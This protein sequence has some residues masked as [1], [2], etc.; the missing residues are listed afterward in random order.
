MRSPPGIAPDRALSVVVFPEPVP[1]LT[2]IDARAATHTRQE[3]GQRAGS[4]PFATRSSQREALAPEAPDRQAGPRQRQRRDHH[5]H[6]RAV[7]QP[8]VA[9]RR[10][11]VDPPP[12]R[13]EDPLD[14][15][16]QLGLA[17]ELDAAARSSRPRRS[18]YTAPRP[19]DHHLVHRRV[20]EQ[21][22]ER[23]EPGGQP[24]H[25]RGQRLAV[26]LGS[27]AASRSTS[28][29]TSSSSARPAAPVARALDQPRPQRDRQLV[30]GL[31]PRQ[32]DEREEFA[33]P[34]RR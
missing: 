32:R 1:P 15:V 9:Q 12:E 23:A 14:R 29:R 24:H 27:G 5:V 31:H 20:G 17:G 10:G 34:A 30:Q 7:R 22:L 33:P 19:V 16:Q 18:T 26:G 3:L 6:A 11:L 21:R 28:A 4:V 25:A 8:R 13:R 2:S